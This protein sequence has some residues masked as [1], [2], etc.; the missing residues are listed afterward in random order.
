VFLLA[1]A[2]AESFVEIADVAL[3]PG[4]LDA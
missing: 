3:G 1:A 4:R 2:A